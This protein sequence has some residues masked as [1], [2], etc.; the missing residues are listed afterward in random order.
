M[1]NGPAFSKIEVRRSSGQKVTIKAPGAESSRYV[2]TLKVNG[3]A[4]SKAWLP[5]SFARSGGTLDFTLG[6]SPNKAFGSAESDAPPSFTEGSKSYVTAVDPGLVPVEPG[7]ST[8][9]TL[10][11]QAL[12]SGGTVEWKAAPPAGGDADAVVRH[13]G[14]SGVRPRRPEDHGLGGRRREDRL[15]LGADRHTRPRR[16]GPDHQRGPQGNDRVVPEQRISDD[17]GPG[18]ANFDGGGWSYSSQ[19]LA[20]AG[21]TPASRCRGTASRS[22]GRRASPA[23]WTTC[24]PRARQSNCRTPPRRASSRSWAPPR[25]PA[26][27]QRDRRQNPLPQRR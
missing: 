23:R 11:V 13:A 9:A 20:A 8:T 14:R 25:I 27:R 22:A 24:R 5:E 19:A 26:L 2:Q 10:R 17:D 1:V 12:S 18:T 16:R 21:L 4:T 3:K 6:T 7:G 15:P